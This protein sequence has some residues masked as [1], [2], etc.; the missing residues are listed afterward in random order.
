MF[1]Q[2]PCLA[3][4]IVDSSTSH[5]SLVFEGKFA[6]YSPMHCASVVPNDKVSNILPF[7]NKAILVL[8]SMCKKL[9]EEFLGCLGFKALDMMNMHSQVQGHTARPLMLLCYPVTAH[10]VVRGLNACKVVRS[11]QLLGVQDGMTADVVIAEELLLGLL[12]KVVPR[13]SG[14]AELSTTASTRGR[15]F[16][17]QQERKA[18]ATR[19]ETGVDVE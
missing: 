12:V 9:F 15:Q 16:M 8:C 2:A 13:P 19:I 17:G 4:V 11:S 18:S 5:V 7:N 10:R 3:A 6:T 1:I 14:V